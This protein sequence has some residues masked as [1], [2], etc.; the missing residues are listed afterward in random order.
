MSSSSDPWLGLVLAVLF[1][2]LF[3]LRVKFP[4][5]S[6]R[7]ETTTL[8][9]TITLFF[10]ACHFFLTGREAAVRPADEIIPVQGVR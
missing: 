4:N 5:A 2:L 3:L 7:T 1:G 8:A 6:R 9:V 10:L